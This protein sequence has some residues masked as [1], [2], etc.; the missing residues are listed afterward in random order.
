MQCSRGQGAPGPDRAGAGPGAGTNIHAAAAGEGPWPR[1]PFGRRLR[2]RKEKSSRFV[3]FSLDKP[4]S[5][6]YTRHITWRMQSC[7][8]P[9]AVPPSRR[10]TACTFAGA[11]PLPCVSAPRTSGAP[12]FVSRFPRP[13]PPGFWESRLLSP[14]LAARACSPPTERPHASADKGR[15]KPP[16][17]PPGALSPQAAERGLQFFRELRD[18]RSVPAAPG[19]RSRG[20]R[21]GTRRKR[22]AACGQAACLGRRTAFFLPGVYFPAGKW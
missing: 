20:E 1:R 7:P 6:W 13:A 4:G 2:R 12:R 16:A 10:G 11:S 19:H 22:G 17:L 8:R 9:T 18:S 3:N 5:L 14:R 15:K 21:Q